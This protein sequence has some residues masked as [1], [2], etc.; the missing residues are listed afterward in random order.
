MQVFCAFRSV[1]E[2]VTVHRPDTPN[3]YATVIAGVGLPW[4]GFTEESYFPD[5]TAISAYGGHEFDSTLFVWLLVGVRG[6]AAPFLVKEQDYDNMDSVLTAAGVAS[7]Q[8][9]LWR[10]IEGGVPLPIP[11]V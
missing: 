10:R 11:Q 8:W 1:P 7:P 9:A 4:T 3:A 6:Q 5:T 2:P